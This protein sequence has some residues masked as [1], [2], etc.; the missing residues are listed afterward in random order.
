MTRSE[1]DHMRTPRLPRDPARRVLAIPLIVIVTAASCSQD[2]PTG[3]D[4]V[5]PVPDDPV[6]EGPAFI[7]TQ[8]AGLVLGDGGPAIT[9][10]GVNLSYDRVSASFCG[11]GEWRIADYTDWGTPVT[12]W[13]QEKHFTMLSEIGFNVVRVNL[14]YRIFEDNANPGEWKQSGWDLLDQLVQWGKNNGIYLILDMHVAPGGAGISA[15]MGC[16]FRTWDEAPYQLRFRALWREIARRYASEPQIAAFDL[17]NEPVP[18]ETAAQWPALA[19]TLIDAIREVDSNHMILMESVNWIFDRNDTSPLAE[20]DEATLRSFQ[21]LVNDANTLYDFHFY[22][23][24][25]YTLQFE[26]GT[27]GGS[28]PDESIAEA[29][30]TG[31][32][33]PR[34]MNFLS[35]E[36]NTVNSFWTTAGVPINYGEWGTEGDV[37][38]GGPDYMRDMLTLMNSRGLSWQFYF[39]NRL[40]DI[41]CCSSDNPTTV[42]SPELIEVFRAGLR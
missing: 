16:G 12:C 31:E 19:Q 24:G 23:P 25:N 14:T 9:L 26:S 11:A 13:Y 7:R 10:R 41:D 33:V 36:M 30:I 39:I 21:S 37:E 22:I 5:D 18:T 2:V 27:D 4:P 6:E 15:C 20:L 3:L 40:Y 34:T 35:G 1:Q 38:K 42:R 17:L 28:Y 32:H 8:G 29:T